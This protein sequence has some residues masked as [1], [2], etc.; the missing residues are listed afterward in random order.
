MNTFAI[1]AIH[2]NIV[3]CSAACT[4]CSKKY[5]QLLY[6][7]GQ[8]DK[9]YEFNSFITFYEHIFSFKIET[10]TPPYFPLL[11]SKNKKSTAVIVRRHLQ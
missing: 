7:S 4:A 1:V 3:K 2:R 11:I 8:Y 6:L 9:L 10:S 5:F